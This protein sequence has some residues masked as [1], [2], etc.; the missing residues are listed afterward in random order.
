M[1]VREE[2]P[3]SRSCRKRVHGFGLDLPWQWV[4]YVATDGGDM[5]TDIAVFKRKIPPFDLRM[6]VEELEAAR[7]AAAYGELEDDGPG[8]D[9]SHVRRDV[10]VMAIA[11]SILELRLD[12]SPSFHD[13]RRLV[14]LY[15]TEP[16][17]T[18]ILLALMFAAKYPGPIGLEEQ[19]GHAQEAARRGDA[20]HAQQGGAD[21][22]D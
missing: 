3:G 7:E 17:S 19:N 9:G 15:F 12:Y 16:T 21:H 11:P 6:V 22:D 14:R 4:D 8:W 1:L 5:P 20:W 13:G 10:G 18:E 2:P